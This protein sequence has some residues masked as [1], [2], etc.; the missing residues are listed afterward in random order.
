MFGRCTGNDFKGRR[1][2]DGSVA[3]RVEAIAENP[4]GIWNLN[5]VSRRIF[6]RKGAKNFG[7]WLS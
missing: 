1:R 3:S 7:D 4:I 6:K 5:S 2:I